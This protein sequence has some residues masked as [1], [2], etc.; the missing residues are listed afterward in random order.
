MA[1]PQKSLIYSV[2]GTEV[3]PLVILRQ[4][5]A[6]WYATIAIEDDGASVHVTQSYSTE[7]DAMHEAERVIAV[8]YPDATIVLTPRRV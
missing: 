8:R 5:R 6:G 4:E 1:F 7:R 2:Q 3:M